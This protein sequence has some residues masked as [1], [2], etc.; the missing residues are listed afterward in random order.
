MRKILIFVVLLLCIPLCIFASSRSVSDSLV[1]RAYKIAVQDD[2]KEHIAIRLYDAVTDSLR[3]IDENSTVYLDKFLTGSFENNALVG[4]ASSGST[5]RLVY[6]FNVEGNAMG[7]Y[8]VSVEMKPFVLMNGE[9]EVESNSINYYFHIMNDFAYFKGTE[10]EKSLDGAKLK[11]TK[12]AGGAWTGADAAPNKVSAS[13]IVTGLSRP[14]SDF[15][16]VSGGVG[17]VLKQDEYALAPN[18]RYKAVATVTLTE[19]S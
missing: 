10:G 6:A 12:S 9:T 4:E 8:T 15:W 11:Y 16:T 5:G 18:G 2:G 14:S 19:N 17:M 1:I 7:S 13:F 3:V